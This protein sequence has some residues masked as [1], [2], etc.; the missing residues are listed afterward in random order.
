MIESFSYRNNYNKKNSNLEEVSNRLKN[1][2]LS[3]FY[4]EEY[5]AY[6]TLE[7]E[8]YTTGI[9]DMMIEMGVKYEFPDNNIYKKRNYDALYKYVMDSEWYTI[10]DFLEKYINIVDD[11]KKEKMEKDFNA[12][13]EQEGSQYRLIK[14]IVTPII[15]KTEIDEIEKASSSEFESV[16]I[17]L[18]KALE[19]F[20]NREKPDYENSIKESITAVEAM[21]CIITEDNKASL[22]KALS[23][24]K[25]KGIH[26]HPGLEAGFKA[27]Y[28][29]TSDED[30]I[31]HGG[32][33][34]IN[35]NAEDARYMLVSCS[36]FVN[37]LK[38]KWRKV[39]Q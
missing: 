12:I 34:F 17:H 20:A 16:N 37:Y 30:G 1:R 3:R 6:D 35:A 11:S 4:K 31:R 39:K 5:Y 36:S 10:Y 26:I 8:N 38:E 27:I 2:I 7:L 23:K 29:Y 13:L 32:V 33:E 21:C 28:G 9:E 14:G 15:S 25:D 18:S 22:G 19:L 24:L